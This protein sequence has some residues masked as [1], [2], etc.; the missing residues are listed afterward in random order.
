MRFARGSL[1]IV[2]G[3]WR[4]ASVATLPGSIAMGTELKKA[5]FEDGQAE[6]QAVAEV[7]GRD[8]FFLLE[9]IYAPTAPPLLRDVPAVELLRQIWIQN[10]FY[11]EGQVR[12]RE[13]ENIPAATQFINSPYDPEA[14]LGKK[15]STM[16]TG[17]KIHLS[18]TCD[19]NLPHL[20]THVATTPARHPR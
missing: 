4:A 5:V 19:E 12:W 16:W 17:Y 11:E 6:R 10:Y 3:E 15:R 2:A 9:E 1:A 14:H 20:I 8:G 13:P 7:I 18:E